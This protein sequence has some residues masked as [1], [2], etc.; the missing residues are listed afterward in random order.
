MIN[1]EAKLNQKG[2]TNV[3]LLIIGIVI[4]ASA[5]VGYLVVKNQKA[6]APPVPAR[7]ITEEITEKIGNSLIISPREGEKLKKGSLYTIRWKPPVGVESMSIAIRSWENQ[8]QERCLSR[9]SY[10]FTI[11]GFGYAVS[12]TGLFS[13]VVGSVATSSA[14]YDAGSGEVIRISQLKLGEWCMVLYVPNRNEAMGG[15]RTFEIIE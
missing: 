11:G 2:F 13:W 6:E 5:G 4:L 1:S 3:L 9:D 15:I 12:N 10:G 14:F 7:N 8:S